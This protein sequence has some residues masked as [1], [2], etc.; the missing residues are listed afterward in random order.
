MR[1]GIL[2]LNLGGCGNACVLNTIYIILAIE[3][4][5]DEARANKACYHKSSLQTVTGGRC[6]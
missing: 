5:E 4:N 6:D 2:L 1:S 3:F